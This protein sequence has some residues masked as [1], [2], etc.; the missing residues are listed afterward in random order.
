MDYT[1]E[2]FDAMSYDID[3]Y[4]EED[5]NDI[6]ELKNQVKAF[7]MLLKAYKLIDYTYG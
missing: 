5:E 4:L 6:D 7:K 3:G 1:M 2:H